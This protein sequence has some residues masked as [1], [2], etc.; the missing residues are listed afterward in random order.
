MSL[1]MKTNIGIPKY[2]SKCQRGIAFAFAAMMNRPGAGFAIEDFQPFHVNRA[3]ENGHRNRVR[4]LESPF[5]SVNCAFVA[6]VEHSWRSVGDLPHASHQRPLHLQSGLH[7]LQ[8]HLVG[9]WLAPG[10][11]QAA[12]FHP[13][14]GLP[15]LRHGQHVYHG[16]SRKILTIDTHQTQGWLRPAP[17]FYSTELTSASIVLRSRIVSLRPSISI[18]SSACKRLKLRETSSRTVPICEAIS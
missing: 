13:S 9:L 17:T 2:S 1:Q 10:R 8:L 14:A 6:L 11:T 4:H 16:L 15:N 5:G 3:I 7:A 12:G 18:N